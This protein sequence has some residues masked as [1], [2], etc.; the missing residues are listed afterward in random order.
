MLR[1]LPP[2]TFTVAD[3]LPVRLGFAC[4]S[5][6]GL[7]ERFGG[8]MHPVDSRLAFLEHFLKVRNGLQRRPS[9]VN[10]VYVKAGWQTDRLLAVRYHV[11]HKIATSGGKYVIRIDPD[12]HTRRVFRHSCLEQRQNQP[13]AA[14]HMISQT[15][16]E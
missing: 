16:V 10:L 7:G 8:I 13:G 1:N 9:G 6:Q 11:Q 14:N 5:C 3:L 4:L 12:V 2:R 15:P